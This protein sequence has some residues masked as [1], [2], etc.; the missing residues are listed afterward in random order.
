MRVSRGE[1]FLSFFEPGE[2]GIR[3][4]AR[5]GIY[6]PWPQSK[7]TL[8]GNW[9][10]VNMLSNRLHRYLCRKGQPIQNRYPTR[11]PRSSNIMGLFF[12]KQRARLQMLALKNQDVNERR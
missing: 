10:L 2:W 5:G 7:L 8:F 6:Q 9:Q 12:P 4:G 1:G 11:S 3:E